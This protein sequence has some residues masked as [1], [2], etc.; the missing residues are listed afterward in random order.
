MVEINSRL[1]MRDVI[2][3]RA[4]Q[5][6]FWVSYESYLH[7]NEDML[8]IRCRRHGRRV[9]AYP[10]FSKSGPVR[11]RSRTRLVYDILVEDCDMCQRERDVHQYSNPSKEE[12]W[13]YLF[14]SS[15]EPSSSSIHELM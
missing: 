11:L 10:R 6:A 12:D 3:M 13:I 7:F 9:K 5:D 8:G 4:E 1:S 14:N 15:A 2:V